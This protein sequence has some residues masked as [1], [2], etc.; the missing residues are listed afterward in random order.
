MTGYR[1]LQ[2]I[3]EEVSAEDYRHS[4]G[5]RDP[6]LLK[7][8]AYPLERAFQIASDY[9]VELVALGLEEL[10]VTPNNSQADL[11]IFADE[12]VI[13]QRLSDQLAAIHRAR[14]ESIHE[15]PDVRAATIYEAG[16]EQVKVVPAFLEAY[17]K[18]LKSLGYGIPV[19]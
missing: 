7:D 17:S 6:Q 4:L 9:T 8:V 13:S 11:Q 1:T 16:E 10:G 18:W 14:N 19:A 12:G 15:C 2:L 5:S 3:L